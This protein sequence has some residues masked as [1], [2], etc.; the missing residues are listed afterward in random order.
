MNLSE[1]IGPDAGDTDEKCKGSHILGSSGWAIWIWVVDELSIDCLALDKRRL[2]AWKL[3]MTIVVLNQVWPGN[4]I[5]VESLWN[6]GSACIRLFH[7]TADWPTYIH[8]V[9][10]PIGSP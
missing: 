4:A 9:V 1:N 7:L 8:Q 10:R 6:V 2:V 5:A 3:N